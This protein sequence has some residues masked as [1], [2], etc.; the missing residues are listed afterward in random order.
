MYDYFMYC[1]TA[2][3]LGTTIPEI[4]ANYVNKNANVYNLP[5]KVLTLVATVFGLC[6]GYSNNDFPL[7]TN[8][9]PFLVLDTISLGMRI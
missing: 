2:L 4:Y 9:A 7:I 8:Y 1:A 5:E 3:F 6:Y